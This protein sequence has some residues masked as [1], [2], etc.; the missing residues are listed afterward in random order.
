[1]SNLPNKNFQQK[2]RSILR[3]IFIKIISII[4]PL[5]SKSHSYIRKELNKITRVTPEKMEDIV[6][7][8]IDGS[9][10]KFTYFLFLV[11]SVI[12]AS[13]GIVNN[14]AAVII[15]AMLI[16]PLM[17][18]IFGASLATVTGNSELLKRSLF[19]VFFG[20]F[21]AI[22]AALFIGLLPLT[23][24]ASTEEFFSRTSPNLL[25]LVIAAFAGIAGCIALLDD[26]VGASLPGVAI[27]TSLAP[28]LGA[29]GLALAMGE[30]GHAWGAFLL[31]FTNFLVIFL[32]SGLLFYF[33][34]FTPRGDRKE[35]W[36]KLKKPFWATIGGIVLVCIPLGQTLYEL[37]AEQS[38]KATINKVFESQLKNSP[39]TSIVKILFKKQHGITTVF[40]ILR[41]PSPISPK[42]VDVIEDEISKK[43]GS[44]AELIVRCNSSVDIIGKDTDGRNVR[45][46]FVNDFIKAESSTEN[47][48]IIIE[49]NIRESFDQKH[50]LYTLRDIEVF[51]HDASLLCLIKV[52]GPRKIFPAEVKLIEEKIKR[53]LNSDSFKLFV[54]ANI[55]QI[56]SSKRETNLAQSL[57]QTL[58]K[59]DQLA[60]KAINEETHKL[61]NDLNNEILLI[62]IVKRKNKWIVI[63]EVTSEI[64]PFTL[65]D[66]QG[67]L[68]TQAKR[69]VA[70]YIKPS[71][72][73]FID[74]QKIWNDDVLLERLFKDTSPVYR[75]IKPSDNP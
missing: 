4:R 50:N 70:L 22:L 44:N 34:G 52:D 57:F 58:S 19:S 5:A 3:P 33:S 31:F 51:E 59:D 21:I 69:D 25:D 62:D 8:I 26:S 42:K 12:I 17:T 45:A 40:A 74:S 9:S 75:N 48:R 71:L 10:P 23:P 67:K 7:E 18:P 63:A 14:S 72:G 54:S 2:I 66:I 55:V 27:A 35:Q 37:K 32:V 15:G 53:N 6:S 38:T 11:I 29:S 49:K 1:V 28:P 13:I 24:L 65:R 36:L 16:S 30:L 41:A 64:T 60:K 43:L 20:V 68:T 73:Y 61:I 46:V 47:N 56:V 39:Q